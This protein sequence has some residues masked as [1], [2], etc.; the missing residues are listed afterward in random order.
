[1]REI[2]REIVGG[3]LISADGK[4]LLG[5][6]VKGGVFEDAWVVPGGGME[7]GET[8]EQTLRREMLE[9]VGIDVADGRILQLDGVPTGSSEK[10]LRDTGERAIVHMNFNDL[11]VRFDRP[12]SDIAIHCDD[13]FEAARWFAPEELLVLDLGEATR[14]RLVQLGLLSN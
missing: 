13:D 7:E 11:V 2:K 3:F 5:H 9:E 10:T 8:K 4:I 14:P 1:M 12:A 6:N